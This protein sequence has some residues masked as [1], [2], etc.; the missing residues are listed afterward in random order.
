MERRKGYRNRLEAGEVLAT[1]LVEYKGKNPLVLA[2]PRGGVP[3]ALPVVRILSCELDLTIPRKIGAPF[4]PEV[5]IGAVCEDGEVLLNPHITGK[6]GVD[7]SYIKKAAAA[8]VREIKRRLSEY[9]GERAPVDVTGRTVIVID[10]GVATGFTITAALKAVKRSKPREL[11]L[12]VPVGAPDS[13]ET[14]AREADKVV[15]PFQP[16]PFYAVGQFYGQF[17]QLSDSDVR[18]MLRQVWEKSL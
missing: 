1:E 2:V 12:A 8:E 18:E 5:A 3:V 15:C 14:L 10:D 13:I 4:Q 6:L 16:E 17:E 7:D 9:R 11:V